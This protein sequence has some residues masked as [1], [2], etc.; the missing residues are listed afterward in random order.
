MKL[1]KVNLQRNYHHIHTLNRKKFQDQ[2]VNKTKQVCQQTR[3]QLIRIF[4]I[5]WQIFAQQG[6]KKRK[7]NRA[8][9]DSSGKF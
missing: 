1:E 5:Y 6:K 8:L 9:K 4:F 7:F 3:S 2:Q